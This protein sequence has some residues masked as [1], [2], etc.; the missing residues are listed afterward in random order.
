[1][2][3][4]PA[5]AIAGTVSHRGP[6][7]GHG[8]HRSWL[9]VAVLSERPSDG[10]FDILEEQPAW[11]QE[12]DELCELCGGE[13]NVGWCDNCRGRHCNE[14]GRC[15]CT[16]RMENPL[17]PGCGLRSPRRPGARQHF[18]GEPVPRGRTTSSSAGNDIE[19]RG[20][21]ASSTTRWSPTA[22]PTASSRGAAMR[23]S[24]RER[25]PGYWQLR[26]YEGTDPVSGKKRYRHAGLGS[27]CRDRLERGRVG[28][29]G[30]RSGEVST[31]VRERDRGEGAPRPQLDRH[32]HSVARLMESLA[33]CRRSRGPK[34]RARFRS[35]SARAVSK[36][37]S[38][39]RRNRSVGPAREP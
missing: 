3:A 38:N 23:G 39:C 34:H 30:E 22:K 33:R 19:S 24:M 4:L 28:G 1:M 16:K 29:L 12:R 13:R 14:S 17:W 11:W 9:A 20:K 31:R 35:R 2:A 25:S 10:Y 6:A 18:G 26:V 21:P 32:S 8:S 37:F 5:R 27:G 7:A 15:A 36:S